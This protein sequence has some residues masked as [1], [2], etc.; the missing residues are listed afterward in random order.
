MIR[1]EI[2]KV[3]A[4][5]QLKCPPVIQWKA[6]YKAFIEWKTIQVW[7]NSL[8]HPGIKPGSAALQADSLSSQLPEMPKQSMLPAKILMNLKILGNRSQTS[9]NICSPFQFIWNS[10]VDKKILAF[11]VKSSEQLNFDEK[12]W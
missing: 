9:N 5:Q 10:K 3:C 6:N 7:K 8:P 12:E 4:T 2:V 1:G 11:K